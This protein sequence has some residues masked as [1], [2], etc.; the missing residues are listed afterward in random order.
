MNVCVLIL[1][2]C[3]YN[4]ANIYALCRNMSCL[5]KTCTLIRYSNYFL[6]SQ[7]KIKWI[8]SHSLISLLFWGNILKF[9]FT[10]DHSFLRNLYAKQ[11]LRTALN[12]AVASLSVK[13]NCQNWLLREN[14]IGFKRKKKLKQ[15]WEKDDRHEQW[16]CSAGSRHQW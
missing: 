13:E 4:H 10:L 1:S 3:L 11:M 8:H 12:I 14:I 7:M 6:L 9:I 15:Q 16:I 2:Y 5:R